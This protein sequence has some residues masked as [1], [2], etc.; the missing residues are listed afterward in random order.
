MKKMNVKPKTN[1]DIDE[2]VK[3]IVNKINNGMSVDSFSISY[4]ESKT[5]PPERYTEA[6]L[7][8]A[9]EHAGK[10]TNNKLEQQALE[11]SSGIGTPATRAE[12]IERIFSAGYVK[13][14]GKSIHPTDKGMQLIELVPQPLRQVSLTAKQEL[15]LE[16][17][18]KV[19][20]NLKQDRA[21]TQIMQFTKL[22][23]LE[24]TRKHMFS[25][26]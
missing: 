1:N 11:D 12:I 15:S 18:K 10:Y 17:F 6:T 9:M 20:K 23:L 19:I 25:G 4:K 8:Y 14:V 21:K 7:L 16:D 26:E 5:T 2:E 13:L 22:N 3:N 24:M